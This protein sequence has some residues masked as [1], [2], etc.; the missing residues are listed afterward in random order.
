MKLFGLAGTAGSGK[1]TAAEII[2][3]LFDMHMFSTSDYVRA[4][5]RYIFDLEP[6]ASPIRD[7]LFEVATEL[8]KLNQAS[9]VNMGIVQARE[10]GFGRQL[11][12]GLR[13]VGEADAI[14]AQGGIIIGVDATPE[15]R[16][17]RIKER[18]RDAESER[19]FE[20]FLR[21]DEHEN[22]GVDG[23]GMKGIR[24]VIE[25]AD[26]IIQNDGT[27]DDLREQISSKLRVMLE[28]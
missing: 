18:S 25:D 16:H 1:D 17:Q 6:D 8:R 3:E 14:R 20:E 24:Y 27:L 12:T 28:Q 7:Q 15:I 10:R 4:V 21:Q 2:A 19:N 5:T 11:I 22:E 26:I 23:E 9:T 13:S